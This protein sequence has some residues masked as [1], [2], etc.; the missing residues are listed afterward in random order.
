MN[1]TGPTHLS[2]RDRAAFA[3]RIAGAVTGFAVIAAAAATSSWDDRRVLLLLAFIIVGGAMAYH[4]LTSIVR[5]PACRRRVYNF[6][7]GPVDAK[8]KLFPCG[9]CGTTAWISEGFYWQRDFN[10]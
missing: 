2:T 8:R 6:G 1:A 5:C 7:I 10:G 9:D 3:L 4:L